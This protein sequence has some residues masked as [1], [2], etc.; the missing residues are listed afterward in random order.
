MFHCEAYPVRAH[1]LLEIDAKH[2]ISAHAFAPEWV[3]NALRRTPFVVVRRGP[4]IE[5]NIPVGVRGVGRNQ[6]WAAF[7]HAKWVK[8]IITPPQLLMCTARVS[9]ASAVAALRA[10]N[11][12]EGR[13]MNLDRPWGPV[14]SVGCEL[15]TGNPVAK[16]QSDLDVVIY[17]ETRLAADEAKS[18]YDSAK[19]LP[20]AVDIRVETPIC[21]FSLGEYSSKTAMTIL[22]R[23][24]C[25]VV[26]GCD[27]WEE[28]PVPETMLATP[29]Q[30]GTI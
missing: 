4:L 19:D 12:L 20:S 23:A 13:W 26:L 24:S 8:S 30:S 3:A 22:L 29:G 28:L 27:P 7:C 11:L 25:G 6:R 16:P 21:G 1:D 17:A 18:L 2:F 9:R 15:A 14:G 10:L 5:Q